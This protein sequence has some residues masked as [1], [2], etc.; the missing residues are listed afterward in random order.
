MNNVFFISDLHFG[1]F[2]VIE[3]SNRPF[4]TAIEMDKALIKNWNKT[5]KST[6][7]IFVLGDFSFYNKEKT[8]TIVEKLNGKKVLIMGNHDRAHSVSWWKEV[9]FQDVY[10]FPLIYK[11]IFIL[12]HVPFHIIDNNI[13]GLVNIHGHLHDNK[14]IYNE[15]FYY[16]ASVEVNNYKPINFLEIQ[17]YFNVKL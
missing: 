4:I 15:A 13:H 16:N 12:S 7:K 9:G 11:E 17:K 1:H 8:K 6:D 3:Y 5:I 14:G 2:N 10:E